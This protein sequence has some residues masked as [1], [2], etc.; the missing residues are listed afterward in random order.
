MA[1]T[2]SGS[3]TVNTDVSPQLTASTLTTVFATAPENLTV[4]QLRSLLDATARVFNGSV[5]T[6]TL[7]SLFN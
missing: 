1:A 6:A 7:G 2:V 4:A 3:K 5:P